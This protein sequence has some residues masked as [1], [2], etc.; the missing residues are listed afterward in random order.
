MWLPPTSKPC[1]RTPGDSE[2]APHTSVELGTA[3]SSS[4]FR[5]VPI[6]VVE[7][8]TRGE[9]PVTVMLSVEPA[10]F[11]LR[12]ERDRLAQDDGDVVALDLLEAG[13]DRT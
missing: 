12:V 6:F 9:S 1:M 8:S 11:H 3:I 2:S 7:T 5:F 13:A 10:D 4:P